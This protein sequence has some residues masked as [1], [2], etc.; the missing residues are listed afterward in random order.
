MRFLALQNDLVAPC[1]NFAVAAAHFGHTVEVVRLFEGRSIPTVEGFDGV[2]ILGGGMGSYDDDSYP[3]IA[4]EK[5]F[6]VDAVQ[7]GVPLLGICLGSQI[8]ADAMGGRAYR[9]DTPE[10]AFTKLSPTVEG[11]A[12]VKALTAGRVLALH[13]DTF[14]LPVGA[15]VTATSDR[16]VHAFRYESA[17]AI[18]SHPEITPEILRGWLA[19]P[20]VGALFGLAGVAA[21]GI[22]DAVVDAEVASREL[23]LSFF[24]AWF[25]EVDYSTADSTVA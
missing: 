17:L 22:L 24:G 25:D 15:T 12:T 23:A 11:D 13:E 10:A 8:L 19:D 1:G 5:A 3:Y 7:A 2:V 6:S 18:Q 20:A 4:A 9:A 16:F 21:D 14:D